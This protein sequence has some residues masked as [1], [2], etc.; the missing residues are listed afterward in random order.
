MRSWAVFGPLHTA[1]S[2]FGNP[3]EAGAARQ[4]QFSIDFEF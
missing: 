4:I 3:I 1:L 2:T